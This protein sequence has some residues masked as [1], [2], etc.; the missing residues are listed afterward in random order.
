MELAEH[1]PGIRGKDKMPDCAARTQAEAHVETH[2]NNRVSVYT[3]GS[4]DLFRKSA[5]AAFVIPAWGVEWCAQLSE[6]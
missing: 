4:V 6:I 5:S 3:D 2:Y 1:I